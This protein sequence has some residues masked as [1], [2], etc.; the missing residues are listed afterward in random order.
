M[1]IVLCFTGFVGSIVCAIGAGTAIAEAQRWRG[2]A[3]VVGLVV[4]YSLFI[5]K[6]VA[7]FWKGV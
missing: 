4:L 6:S 1:S 7:I 2:L 3:W 5:M